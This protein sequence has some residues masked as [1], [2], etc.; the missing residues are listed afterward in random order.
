M[1]ASPSTR[2]RTC[3]RR[4]RIHIKRGDGYTSKEL[5]NNH[6]QGSRRPP[7]WLWTHYINSSYKC[8]YLRAVH[9]RLLDS[10][11]TA[12]RERNGHSGGLDGATQ[13]RDRA[14]DRLH[15]H[16]GTIW[17]ECSERTLRSKN[18][19]QEFSHVRLSAHAFIWVLYVRFLLNAR[20]LDFSAGCGWMGP[21]TSQDCSHLED[22]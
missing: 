19:S 18:T 22:E 2:G 1:L 6:S 16:K 8:L 3:W 12:A 10:E 21:L 15:A 17:D 7:L 14:V 9:Q 11:E 4:R 20:H 5:P 13:V